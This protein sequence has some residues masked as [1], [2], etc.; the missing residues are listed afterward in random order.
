MQLKMAIFARKR[1]AHKISSER[2]FGSFIQWIGEFPCLSIN[3]ELVNSVTY[4]SFLQLFRKK[5]R[6]SFCL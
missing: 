1:Q 2:N 6:F 3:E 5:A 4:L